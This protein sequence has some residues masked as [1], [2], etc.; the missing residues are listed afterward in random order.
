MVLV[1]IALAVNLLCALLYALVKIG[2]KENAGIAVFFLFLPV[3]GFAICFLPR[4]IQR[5]LGR[6]RYDRDSLVQRFQIDRLAAHPNVREELSVVPVED[7]MA[8]S[9]NAE[10]RALLLNQLKKDAGTSYRVLLAAESDQD[11]ESVHYVAAAKMEAYRVQQQRWTEC[12]EAYIKDPDD[13]ENYHAACAALGTIIDSGVLSAREKGMYQRRYCSLIPEQEER[14]ADVIRQEEYESYLFYL[15]DLNE[16]DRACR[17]WE[18]RWELVKSEAAYMKMME[19]F[20]KTSDRERFA[21]CV[22]GL[23]ADRDI[24]LSA[25]GLEQLRYWLARCQEIGSPEAGEAACLPNCR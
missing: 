17:I 10:K 19:L 24:R 1:W 23:Q 11:S 2:R 7:A 9:A 6:E 13:P 4:Q 5:L 25:Q 18:E 12:R 16:Y 3:L 21:A 14:G 15:I 8:V 20:Y 22:R